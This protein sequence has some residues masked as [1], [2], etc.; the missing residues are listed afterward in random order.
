MILNYISL[1]TFLISFAIGLFLIYILGDD[2]KTVF[3]Y[4]TPETVDRVLFRDA[5]D[6]CFQVESVEVD[7][8]TNE[9]LINRV[10]V[11]TMM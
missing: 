3:I 8:P 9:S 11:Q 7:C 10:P 5:T 4:P 1:S 6:N 2:T